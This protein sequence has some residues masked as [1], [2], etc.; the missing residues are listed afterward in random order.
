MFA[1]LYAPLFRLQAALRVRPGPIHGPVALAETGRPHAPLLEVNEI[2]RRQGVEPGLTPTQALARCPELEVVRPDAASEVAAG[3]MLLSR[4]RRMAPVVEASGPGLVLMDV[5]TLG[6]V[7]DWAGWL[8]ALGAEVPGLV[9]RAGL[10]PTP[11]VAQL[12]AEEGRPSRMVKAGEEGAFL[13]GLPVARVQADAGRLAV[14]E[15]WGVRTLG[16]LAALGRRELVARWGKEGGRLWDRATGRANRPLVPWEEAER[17]VEGKEFEVPVETVEPLLFVLRR[18]IE[19]LLGRL[20]ERVLGVAGLKLELGL[21]DGTRWTARL[22]LPEPTQDAGRLFRVVHQRL[23]GVHTAAPLTAV[24]LEAMPGL[25]CVRQADLF[26]EGLK[27]EEGLRETLA[28]LAALVGRDRV[29]VPVRE[30][31]HEPDQFRLELRAPLSTANEG[32]Q[33]GPALVLRRFRPPVVAQVRMGNDGPAAFCG[34]AFEEEVM[35]A[36]GP[37]RHSG[38]WWEAGRAWEREEWDVETRGGRLFR[39]AR[40]GP[41][42]VVEGMYD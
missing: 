8:Q 24:W 6:R 29:G 31:T 7:R 37:W 22:E 25:V 30:D 41:S 21:A 36:R 27:R 16:D 3:A 20:Q 42:W 11:W 33:P 32:K 18:L 17:W 23:D 28:R 26:A 34:D 12:A 13:A 4:A 40:V 2:A 39:L 1:A 15:L 10:G 14:L 35:R 38:N 9:V 5:R 19:L